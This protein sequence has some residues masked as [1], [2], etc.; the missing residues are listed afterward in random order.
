V[1]VQQWPIIRNGNVAA[2][3]GNIY[4]SGTVMDRIEIYYAKLEETVPRR[5]QQ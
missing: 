5:L 2:K 1:I 4:I 3:T